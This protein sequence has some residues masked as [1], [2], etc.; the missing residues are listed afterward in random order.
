MTNC[1]SRTLQAHRAF[2]QCIPKTCQKK[3]GPRKIK[4][5]NANSKD[6]TA[7]PQHYLRHYLLYSI[8]ADVVVSG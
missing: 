6:D 4:S 3:V 2:R 5:Q 8:A 7:R 1:L